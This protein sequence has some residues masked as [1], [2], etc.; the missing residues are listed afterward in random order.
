MRRYSIFHA[1]PLSF[2]SGGLYR[3]VARSWRGIG[4]VYLML[5][6]ALATL[7]VV[8]RMQVGLDRFVHGEARGLVEQIPRIVI[9]HRVVEVDAVMPYTIH[10]P[11]TGT[12]F[13]IIDTTG[14]VTSLDGQEAMLL[15]TSDHILFRKSTAETRVFQLAGVK[16]FTIDQARAGHWL[17]AFATWAPPILAVF[18]FGGLFCFRLVQQLMLAVIG[19]LAARAMG[20][21][22][23]FSALMR[24]AA[25]ALTPALLVEPLLD[26]LKVKLPGFGMLWIILVLVYIVW[27]V[28]SNRPDPAA[29]P[30]AAPA[31]PA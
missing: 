9:R 15:V 6:V 18:I 14:Q 31:S 29:T 12:P 19:L 8:I 10:G 22:L 24:L 25:V 11:K 27:A 21:A 7:V 13:A 16:D 30:T 5:L 2:F 26:I 17:G 20:A 23:D 4:L 3:D 1:L 28:H